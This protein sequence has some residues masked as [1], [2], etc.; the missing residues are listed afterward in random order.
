MPAPIV[1]Q[2]NRELAEAMENLDRNRRIAGVG[3]SNVAHRIALTFGKP[4]G[5]R[6]ESEENQGTVVTI[7]VP[8]D[9]GFPCIIPTDTEQREDRRCRL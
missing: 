9:P 4:Y 3:L 6:I 1:E 5:I 8:V 2:F 7:H